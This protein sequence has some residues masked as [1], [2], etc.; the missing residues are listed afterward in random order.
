MISYEL[1]KQL[2]DAGFPLI[3]MLEKKENGVYF[4]TAEPKYFNP[5]LSELIEACREAL[6]EIVIYITDGSVEVKGANPLYG[7][8]LNIKGST[9]EEAVA[10]LW[11]QL[12]K[13]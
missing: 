12:N 10:Q 5:T 7:L 6:D 2:K 8:D 13:S 1:A 11:L 4:S 3:R 9:P